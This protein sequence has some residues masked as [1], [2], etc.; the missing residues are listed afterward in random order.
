MKYL[1]KVKLVNNY[2][3]AKYGLNIGDIGRIISAEIRDNEFLVNFID[4]N[5]EIHKNEPKWFENMCQNLKMIFL[6]L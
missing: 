2:E 1:D 6:Y 5:F 3:Y 4:K